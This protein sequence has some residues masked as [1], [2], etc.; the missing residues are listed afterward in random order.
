MAFDQRQIVLGELI[1]QCLGRSGD[2]YSL[3]GKQG[4]DEIG[5]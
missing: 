5:E 1:L 3:P 4:R 2:D